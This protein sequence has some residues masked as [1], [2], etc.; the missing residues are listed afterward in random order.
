[1]RSFFRF[2]QYRAECKLICL[3]LSSRRRCFLKEYSHV[4]ALSRCCFHRTERSVLRVPLLRGAVVFSVT[5]ASM[6]RSVTALASRLVLPFPYPQTV[7]WYFRGGVQH[8]HV[9]QGC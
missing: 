2:L 7:L 4:T 6:C 1:M 5:L 9:E 3:A 8:A